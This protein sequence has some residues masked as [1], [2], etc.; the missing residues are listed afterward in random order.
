MFTNNGYYREHVSA[1]HE[2][3]TPFNCDECHRSFGTTRRLRNHKSL[4]HKRVKCEEC[5]KEICNE[6]MLKRHKAIAHGIQPK[7]VMQCEKCP[8]FFATQATLDKHITS[9]ERN[10]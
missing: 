10:T 2:K 6:F 9:N 7:D 4:V 3:Q 8:L 1:K 5:G